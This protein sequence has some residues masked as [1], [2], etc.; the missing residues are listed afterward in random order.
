MPHRANGPVVMFLIC[1]FGLL[2][3]PANAEV[4]RIDF[5]SKQPY[6]T[7]RGATT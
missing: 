5:T 1:L 4:T 2:A 7:F 3:A 6:G